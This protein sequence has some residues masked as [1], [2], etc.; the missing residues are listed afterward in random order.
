MWVEIETADGNKSM[1]FQK[2]KK[3]K[4]T[5]GRVVWEKENTPVKMEA[6][7]SFKNGDN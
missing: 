2:Y 7:G 4:T 3:K 1:E 6:R 5:K